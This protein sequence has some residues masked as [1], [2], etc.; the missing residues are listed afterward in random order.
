MW[1]YS[2]FSDFHER[3]LYKR[4]YYIALLTKPIMLILVCCWHSF[5]ANVF[6]EWLLWCTLER[7][8][9]IFFRLSKV[10]GWMSSASAWRNGGLW[11]ANGNNAINDIVR[12]SSMIWWWRWSICDVA[13]TEK[14]SATGKIV[15]LRPGEKSCETHWPTHK[16]RCLMTTVTEWNVQISGNITS[17]EISSTLFIK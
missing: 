9:G 17:K 7:Q 10:T 15:K 14:P 1:I 8:W 12:W 13:Q 4:T 5:L 11:S 16:Q 2:V 6:A 3:F